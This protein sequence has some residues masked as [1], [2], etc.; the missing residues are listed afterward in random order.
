MQKEEVKDNDKDRHRRLW[1]DHQ[2]QAC[3]GIRTPQRRKD[4]GLV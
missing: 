3:A 1:H 4:R 2:D